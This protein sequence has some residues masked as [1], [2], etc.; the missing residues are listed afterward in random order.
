MYYKISKPPRYCWHVVSGQCDDFGLSVKG[1]KN[2]IICVPHV[3]ALCPMNFE[4]K[5]ELQDL[6]RTMLLN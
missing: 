6:G 5:T 4:R 1:M 2:D 3:S